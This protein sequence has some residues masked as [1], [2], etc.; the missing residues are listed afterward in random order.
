VSD[1][2]ELTL[3]IETLAD[4]AVVRCRGGLSLTTAARLR[5]E[6]KR[7]SQDTRVVTIDFTDLTLID[8]VGI[9]TMVALYVSAKSAGREL[10]VVNM[11]RE[12]ARSSA[13]RDCWRCSRRPATRTS[14]SPDLKPGPAIP[15]R[16]NYSL[17]NTG[18]ADSWTILPLTT[19]STERTLLI[20]TSGTEK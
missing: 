19:V 16:G 9:G 11:G 5:H 13:S 4:G 12:F 15:V 10:H 20:S 1:S 6:V 3:D 7:L 18:T 14:G 17:A 2:N 8:S